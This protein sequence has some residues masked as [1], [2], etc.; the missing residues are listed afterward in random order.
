MKVSI[1]HDIE[2]YF[3][4]QFFTK[5]YKLTIFKIPLDKFFTFS[6]KL[7]CSSVRN[8]FHKI[9]EFQN[10]LSRLTLENVANVWK[11]AKIAYL[12]DCLLPWQQSA[13]YS[14]EHFIS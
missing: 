13:F 10:I 14:Y 1:L 9:V 5:F 3:T 2:A 6:G 11:I 8:R 4:I 7:K 12:Y